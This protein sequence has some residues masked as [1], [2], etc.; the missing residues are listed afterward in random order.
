MNTND[1]IISTLNGLIEISRD[2][3]LGFRTCAE[4]LDSPHLKTLFTDR[5]KGC[6]TAVAELQEQV[7]SLGGKAESE[8]S[9]SGSLHRRWIDIKAAILG[10]NNESILTECHR[11]EDVALH[12]YRQALAK[13]LTDSARAVVERQYAGVQKNHDEVKALL[14]QAKSQG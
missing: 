3:E 6:A 10:K 5:S 7:R 9:V 12:A 1:D 2:G 13:D 4:D 11:G 8:T 14:A